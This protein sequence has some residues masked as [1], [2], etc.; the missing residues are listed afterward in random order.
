MMGLYV[1]KHLRPAVIGCHEPTRRAFSS[2]KIRY[3]T[4]RAAHPPT[5][6]TRPSVG[7]HERAPPVRPLFTPGL[8][9]MSPYITSIFGRMHGT[10]NIDKKITNCTI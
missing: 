9:Q 4:R 1:K 8:V 6:S 2:V 10:V 3:V 7:P 5:W